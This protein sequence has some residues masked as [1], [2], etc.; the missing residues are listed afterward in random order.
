MRLPAQGLSLSPLAAMPLLR[1]PFSLSKK[2]RPV[3]VRYATQLTNRLESLH[4]RP[5]I[6]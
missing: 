6:E 5:G 4:R 2:G 1:Y 3:P